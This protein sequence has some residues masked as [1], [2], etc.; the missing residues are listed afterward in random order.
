MFFLFI[1]FDSGYELWIIQELSQYITCYNFFMFS[2][3]SAHK[4]AESYHPRFF[5]FC[6][7]ISST[8]YTLILIRNIFQCNCEVWLF[9]KNI[10]YIFAIGYNCTK[11][12]ILWFG[13]MNTNTFN[14]LLVCSAKKW[15]IFVSRLRKYIIQ[16]VWFLADIF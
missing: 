1:T 6:S 13:E 12:I 5:F 7:L 4:C 2:C 9:K 10:N 11:Q 14:Y 8:N 3:L 15:L 16:P